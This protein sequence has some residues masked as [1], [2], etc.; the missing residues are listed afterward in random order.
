MFHFPVLS[1]FSILKF[2]IAVKF[3]PQKSIISQ[4]VIFIKSNESQLVIHI[5]DLKGNGLFRKSFKLR[6]IGKVSKTSRRGTIS[7][8]VVGGGQ[9]SRDV[10]L[11]CNLVRS[12]RY[13]VIRHTMCLHPDIMLSIQRACWHPRLSNYIVTLQNTNHRIS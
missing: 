10:P 13:S 3:C 5:E 9:R 6:I 2:M 8:L 4:E 12:F 11:I 1:R 7:N